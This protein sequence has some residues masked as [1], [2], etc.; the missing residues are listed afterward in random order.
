VKKIAVLLAPG[1]DE[2]EAAAF[3]EVFGWARMSDGVEPI[4]AETLAVERE[5]V[6]AHGMA[7]RAHLRIAD[8][9]AATYAGAAVPGGIHEKGYSH[10]YDAPVLDCL[11]RI[12]ACGGTIASSS[13]GSR[14]LAAAGLLVGK[15]ATTYPFDEGRHRA[16][17]AE[18]GATLSDAEIERDGAIITGQSPASALAVALELL[19]TVQGERAVAAA[20]R[21]MGLR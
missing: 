21:R 16:Y 5:V 7:V 11:R 14:V 19:L 18:C 3:V 13:T 6:G 15:R 4:A 1:F 20:K 10:A 17:L 12:E 2:L 8:A 9:E